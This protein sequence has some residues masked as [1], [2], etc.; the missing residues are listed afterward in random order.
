MSDGLEDVVA[1]NTVMSEVDGQRGV[2][3]IRGRS[4]DELAGATR[5]EDLVR[6]LFDGFFD[7]LPADLARPWARPAPRCSPRSPPSIP[8]C[9]T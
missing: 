9:S 8:A 4:L 5:F 3:I 1:A 7:Q 6:T 2:L